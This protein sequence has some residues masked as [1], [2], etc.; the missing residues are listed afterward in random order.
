MVFCNRER[1]SDLRVLLL[2]VL[3]AAT[4]FAQDGA[5][6]YK[7]HCAVCHDSATGRVPST[8][9]LRTMSSAAILQ[10][11]EAGLMKTE[12]TPLTSKEQNAVASYLGAPNRSEE[13][14]V[15][16]EWRCR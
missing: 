4:V 12:S 6:V 11:L 9:T 2:L 3:G 10:S 16:K 14:R 8:S 15:G 7:A 1:S 13:R 5:A